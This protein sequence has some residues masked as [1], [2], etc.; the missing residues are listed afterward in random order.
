MDM[1]NEKTE[2][3]V[4]RSG[5]LKELNREDAQKRPGGIVLRMIWKMYENVGLCQK[6]AQFRNKW[7]RRN[8][9]FDTVEWA[10]RR[11]SGL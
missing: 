10:T 7:K 4:V 5:R 9:C 6:D 8:Q 2:S 3:N 11:A 1:L